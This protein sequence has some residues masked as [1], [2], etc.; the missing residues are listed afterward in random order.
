[1]NRSLVQRKAKT[2][3]LGGLFGTYVTAIPFLTLLSVSGSQA[4]QVYGPDTCM[5]GYV[6]RE[7]VPSDHVCVTPKVRQ[8]TALDNQAAG[9]RRDPQGAYGSDTCLSGYVWR[10]AFTNDHVCV[11]PAVRRQAAYDNAMAQS[12]IQK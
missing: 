10:E 2:I 6:W 9:S 12:R 1:M 3:T 7:A 8:Q 5:A 11:T 4:A